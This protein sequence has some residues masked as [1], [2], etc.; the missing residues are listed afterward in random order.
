MNNNSHESNVNLLDLPEEIWLEI[1]EVCELDSLYPIYC[2][3]KLFRQIMKN[4]NLLPLWICSVNNFS[5]CRSRQQNPESFT[6]NFLRHHKFL[7]KIKRYKLEFLTHEELLNPF[8]NP[9]LISM[10]NMLEIDTCI[11]GSRYDYQP[12]LEK[13]LQLP[14]I[15]MLSLVN[16]NITSGNFPRI[17]SENQFLQYLRLRDGILSS[18]INFSTCSF[19]DFSLDNIY[20]ESDTSIKMPHCL[21]KCD[22]NCYLIEKG[23]LPNSF[24]KFQMSHCKELKTL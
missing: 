1:I 22:L 8:N 15:I 24:I 5:T 18:F 23:L 16:I 19:V 6:S 14:N 2:V 11:L 13:A 4:M 10:I 7:Q 3:N 17:C 20:F 12:I 9:Q 21:K